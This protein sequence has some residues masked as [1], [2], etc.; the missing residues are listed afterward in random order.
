MHTSTFICDFSRGLTFGCR[1]AND[2]AYTE[3]NLSFVCLFGK[4]TGHGLS[5]V[6][7]WDIDE[8][9]EYTKF[10]KFIYNFF[11]WTIKYLGHVLTTKSLGIWKAHVWKFRSLRIWASE[12]GL[13]LPHR[14]WKSSVLWIIAFHIWKFKSF[15]IWASESGLTLLHRIRKSSVLWIIALK[16]PFLSHMTRSVYSFPLRFLFCFSFWALKSTQKL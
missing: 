1:L 8:Q 9:K 14:I 16:P 7:P 15:R 13:T 4:F 11:F 12:S 2:E 10:V 6:F 5:V 3:P